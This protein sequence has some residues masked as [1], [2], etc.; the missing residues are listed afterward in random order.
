MRNIKFL[1]IVLFLTLSLPMMVACGGDDEDD[2]INSP[3]NYIIGTWH[4]FKGEAFYRGESSV[5]AIEKKGAYSSA[6]MEF[7]FENG[8]KCTGWWWA[9]DEYNLSHWTEGYGTYVI[10]N[11]IITITDTGGDT[12]DLLYD[13]KDKT[14]ML[15]SMTVIDGEYITTNIYFKK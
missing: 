13:S 7:K 9:Q 4:S 5:V 3:D 10:K 1:R 11:N 2:I 14:L 8:N 6:Y 15:R 12:V